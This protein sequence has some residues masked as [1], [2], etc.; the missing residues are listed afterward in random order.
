MAYLNAVIQRLKCL[1]AEKKSIQ[2]GEKS[3]ISSS[4]TVVTRPAI[5]SSHLSAYDSNNSAKKD[6]AEEK[7][8][9][10]VKGNLFFTPY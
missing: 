7:L 10:L 9:R 6:D 4:L 2:L 5:T 1:K 3:K 8:D